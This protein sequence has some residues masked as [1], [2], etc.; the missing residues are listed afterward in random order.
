MNAS[1][2]G[3]DIFYAHLAKNVCRLN[4]IKNKKKK[5]S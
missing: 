2:A 4:N 5:D 3:T 1:L